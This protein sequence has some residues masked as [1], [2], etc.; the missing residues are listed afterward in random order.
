[1][2]A[3]GEL[4]PENPSLAITYR[5]LRPDGSMIWLERNSRAHFDEQGKLQRI[6]ESFSAKMYYKR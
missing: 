4:S 6:L 5:M 2:A 3:V 1:M